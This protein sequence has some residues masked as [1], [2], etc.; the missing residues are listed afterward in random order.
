MIPY[1][2]GLLEPPKAKR[3]LQQRDRKPRGVEIPANAITNTGGCLVSVFKRLLG[4]DGEVAFCT[5]RGA[6]SAY[7]E[8]SREH[9]PLTSTLERSPL[10]TLRSP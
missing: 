1:S 4:R 7:W 2:R 6:R 8:R 10:V 3:F 5:R 9:D